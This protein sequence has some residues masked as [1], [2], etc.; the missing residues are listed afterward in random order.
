MADLEQTGL[1]F[2][3][4]GVEAFQGAID[5]A[6]KSVQNFEDTGVSAE[7]SFDGFQEIVTGALRKVGEV[8]IDMALSAGKAVVDFA[9]NSFQAA[10]DA[11]AGLARLDGAIK[12]AG[13]DAPVTKEQA[14]QLAQSLKG[15][16][17][18]SDEAVVA[19][20]SVLLKFQS[21]G[22]DTFPK[23][24]QASLDLAAVLG[25]DASSAAEQLGRALGNTEASARLLKQA[26]I[27]LTDEEKAQ[28]KAM[29]DAGD[30]AGAQQFVLDKLATTT[31]GA[32]E[33][34]ANTVGGQWKIFQNEVEDAGKGIAEAFLPIIKTLMDDYLKPLLPIITDIANAIA[35][36]ISTAFGG[37]GGNLSGI[38]SQLKP[39]TD[40]LQE[41][42]ATFAKSAPEM[43]TLGKDLFS[44]LNDE[45]GVS[46]PTIIQNLVSIIQALTEIWRDH[47][48]QIM[49]IIEVAFKFI[50][51]TISGT[52]TLITGIISVALEL[53]SGAFDFWTAVFSGNWSKAWNIVLDTVE[54]IGDTIIN[55]VT[56]FVGQATSI[57]TTGMQDAVSAFVMNLTSG[58]Q[59]GLIN[60]INELRN[61][62]GGFNEAGVSLM[63]G[64]RQGIWRGLGWI[65]DAAVGVAQAAVNAF[66]DIWNSHSPSRVGIDLG[67]SLPQGMAI[68]LDRGSSLIDNA[69][70]QSIMPS[71]MPSQMF[72]G[73]N[74]SNNQT[75]N[76]NLNVDSNQSS[77]GI[78]SDFSIM[79]SMAGA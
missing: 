79:R 30:A 4:E 5:D 42:F 60:A 28:I 35:G 23:A 76:F 38:Q 31:A 29:N 41:L 2:I 11:E 17:G 55:T 58:I 44:F 61:W 34:M 63:D 8:A 47:G 40:A 33:Q 57:A 49:T 56:S 59:T 19:A 32:A 67:F 77:Q 1:E 6:S 75:S 53:I 15:L 10:I 25:T 45:L 51:A 46:L 66:R 72:S 7:S 69:M 64:L 50:F 12:R 14:L 36:Q 52:V 13:A 18:G 3:A 21:I 68:G 20:E 62:W 73:G 43:Q 74:V 65:I 54:K 9:T 37:F 16:A 22:K 26:G 27:F 48:T 71:M 24:L 70:Q 39:I 78:S